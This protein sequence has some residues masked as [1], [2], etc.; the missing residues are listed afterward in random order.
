MRL[1]KARI[2][3][4]TFPS[5]NFLTRSSYPGIL[6]LILFFECDP[7]ADDDRASHIPSTCEICTIN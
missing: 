3:V 5:A 7:S 6:T 1:P 4:M 2:R